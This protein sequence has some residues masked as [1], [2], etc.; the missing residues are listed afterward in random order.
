[1]GLPHETL[2]IE[3]GDIYV[4]PEG[5]EQFEIVQSRPTKF[6]PWRK[7]FTTTIT[8]SNAMTAGR[9][10][11]AL[12]ADRFGRGRLEVGGSAA[13]PTKPPA[14]TDEAWIRYQHFIPSQG[15]WRDMH[16]RGR[17]S[18]P[19][20]PHLITD[21]YAYDTGEQDGS[22]R[23]ARR[24]DG[25]S[26][27]RRLDARSHA[28][29]AQGSGI[30]RAGSGQ[31]RTALPM[32]VERR[33]P[34]RPALGIDGLADFQPTAQTGIRGAGRHR[35]AFAN[36]DR[37]LLLW[38]DDDLVAFAAPTAYEDLNNAIPTR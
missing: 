29:R 10:A 33:K 26:L 3:Q 27:G 16:G 14:A 15:D 37:Q 23:R 9:L 35:V 17:V 18:H 1:M 2:Q 11:A 31:G 5:G 20:R 7:T 13:V 19:P 32:R 22:S 8:S 4:K 6:G 38:M 28:R 24:A 25:R 34:A 30:G 12:A 21:F 36:V